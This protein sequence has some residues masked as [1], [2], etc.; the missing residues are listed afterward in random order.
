MVKTKHVYHHVYE[1]N[2]VDESHYIS[3]FQ[4]YYFKYQQLY[5][6]WQE[7]EDSNIKP[8]IVKEV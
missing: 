4:R 6:Q 7:S 5:S 3:L 2:Y 1:Y 8:V